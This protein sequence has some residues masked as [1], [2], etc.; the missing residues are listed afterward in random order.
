V[1]GQSYLYPDVDRIRAYIYTNIIKGSTQRNIT[2]GELE[3]VS[4]DLA[5]NTAAKFYDDNYI[6]V[7]ETHL[8][9]PFIPDK[10]APGQ[11]TRDSGRGLLAAVANS[12]Q[13]Y[14]N[15]GGD[16]AV[17]KGWSEI[18]PIFVIDQGRGEYGQKTLNYNKQARDLYSEMA[19]GTSMNFIYDW[20]TKQ[21][22]DANI[23]ALNQNG[24]FQLLNNWKL[25]INNKRQTTR[26]QSPPE[27][28]IQRLKKLQY[29]RALE[30]LSATERATIKAAENIYDISYFEA[31]WFPKPSVPRN[32][33]ALL[34]TTEF[35]ANIYYHGILT[36]E[37]RNEITQN[38]KLCRRTFL[39]NTAAIPLFLFTSFVTHKSYIRK[40][41]TPH[42]LKDP[43]LPYVDPAGKPKNA[44]MDVSGFNMANGDE[45]TADLLALFPFHARTFLKQYIVARKKL[46]HQILLGLPSN[47]DYAEA[48]T[49]FTKAFVNGV[50]Q[51]QYTE[52]VSKVNSVTRSAAIDSVYLRPYTNGGAYLDAL[53]KLP[54]AAPT[55]AQLDPSKIVAP[56]VPTYGVNIGDR[57]FLDSLAQSFYEL[58]DGS[59][60]MTYIYDVF[61]VGKT[62]F[63]VRFDLRKHNDPAEIQKKID[64]LKDTYYNILKANVDEVTINS[65]RSDYYS[66]LGD[67]QAQQSENMTEPVRG[68]VGRFF[69]EAYDAS[70]ARATEGSWQ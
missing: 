15:S 46:Y 60:A 63:D 27:D 42:Y 2:T 58:T 61:T 26:S 57:Y 4:P 41:T 30:G 68:V 40:D 59:F 51:A 62:I 37:M 22:Y 38:Y 7:L 34:D 54:N 18:Q 44:I 17:L 39:G 6:G 1:T 35:Q 25:S 36:P 49:L 65:A 9:G 28:D 29:M 33:P 56:V 48:Y 53:R 13:A 16:G 32:S 19:L 70:G 20:E 21:F 8:Y 10:D 31:P 66:N 69:I 52:R 45:L 50:V 3:L 47:E 5:T 64:A 43:V 67:L 23:P 11:F 14:I 55:P 24:V 12:R